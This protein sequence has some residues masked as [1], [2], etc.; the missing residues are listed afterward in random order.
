MEAGD[1]ETEKVGARGR[2]WWRPA[3]ERGSDRSNPDGPLE[4]AQFEE[5]VSAVTDYAIFVLDPDGHVRTWNDGA[6]QIKGYDAAEIVGEHFSRFY[7]PEDREAGRPERNLRAAAIEGRI[8]DEG[9]RLRADGSRFWANVTITALADDAGELRGF[10]KVTRDMTERHEYEE[11]IRTQRDELDDLA[12]INAVIR[13]IDQAMV[14]ATSREEVEAAVCDR[15]G[16]AGLYAGAWIA[17]YAADHE[18][19]SVRES[20]GLDDETRDALARGDPGDGAVLGARALRNRTVETATVGESADAT[21]GDATEGPARD[22]AGS[23]PRPLIDPTG[24]DG[25]AAAAVPLVFDDVE[26]GVLTV[27]R[28]G[29]T[30]FDERERS[31]LAELG[32]TASHA[33]AALRSRERERTLTVLQESTRELLQATTAVEIGDVIVETL[34]ADL[35]LDDAVVYR[36]D[37][38]D[39]ALTP[40]S[41][42]TGAGAAAVQPTVLD[43]GADSPVLESFMDGETLV[44]GP[45]ERNG[46]SRH[47]VIVPVGDHG[48]L[49]VGAE[50]ERHL[51]RKTR[52]VIELVAATAEAAFDR[53]ESQATLR[54]REELLQEQNQRLQRVNQINTVIREVDQGLVEATTREE[55]E[56]VVCER[57]AESDRARIFAV[58]ESADGSTLRDVLGRSV[59]VESARVLASRDGGHLLE[60]EVSG[61]TL[62][63][64]LL[65]ETVAVRSLVATPSSVSLSV[66]VPARSDVRGFIERFRAEYDAAEFVA[67]RERER[68][69]QTRAGLFARLEEELTD[70]QFEVL[71]TAYYSG[72]F[73][74]PRESTG[75]DVA[76]LLGVS[77]PTVT[78]QLRA[79]QRKLLDVLLDERVGRPA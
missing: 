74:S 71:Q 10:V 35:G 6:E 13:E 3:P 76:D 34:T 73:D 22:A 30:A 41:V 48:V 46:V 40:A 64:D 7:V 44:A 60:A 77:Q 19:A 16:A 4:H 65:E 2:V 26:Y 57:L 17:E 43:P 70:R 56:R 36:F 38:E 58:A 75:G 1:L 31:V 25:A 39:N 53:V 55:V 23:E 50:D 62:A 15:L 63:L 14:A 32:E 33:I 72:Y 20:A 51:D 61:A 5:L 68:P 79:A 24:G 27:V 47:T 12:R 52:N 28:D 49:A 66:E 45:A 29:P 78:E 54:E 11:R 67:R 9:W 18:T 42:A 69:V 37:T 59:V 8:E 21:A